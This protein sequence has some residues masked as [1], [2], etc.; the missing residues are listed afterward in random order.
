MNKMNEK[1][2]FCLIQERTT[3]SASVIWIEILLKVEFTKKKMCVH[4][5]WTSSY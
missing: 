1:Q 3:T 5:E 2:A 4:Y